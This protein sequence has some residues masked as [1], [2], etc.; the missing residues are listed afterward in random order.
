MPD[1]EKILGDAVKAARLEQ[2]L[3][4]DQV[5]EMTGVDVRTVMN[6]EHYRD[7]PK[8]STLFPLV[9][10]LK[11]DARAIFEPNEQADSPSVRQLRFLTSDCTE[12]EAAT[13][14]PVLEAVLSALRANQKD[15]IE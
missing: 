2:G 6:I 5:A 1:I 4:L 10:K 12:Q 9:R 13:L 11:L 7:N 8:F 14:L 15:T 3:T